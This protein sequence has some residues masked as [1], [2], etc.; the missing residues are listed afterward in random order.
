M[1]II[2]KAFPLR[3][4]MEE[5]KSTDKTTKKPKRSWKKPKDK[6]FRALSAYNLFFQYQRERIVS[7]MDED[8]SPEEISENIEK[9]LKCKRGPKKRKDRISHNRISFVDLAKSIAEKWKLIDPKTKEIFDRYASKEKVRYQNEL[10]SWKMRKES[11]LTSSSNS[12]HSNVE[13]DTTISSTLSKRTSHSSVNK[14]SLQQLGQNNHEI[15]GDVS[16]ATDTQKLS[17]IRQYNMIQRQQS[18][19]K[20][21]MGF[22]QRY[23]FISNFGKSCD[24]NHEDWPSLFPHSSRSLGEQIVGF[25]ST[26]INSK[27]TRELSKGIH[28]SFSHEYEV[29]SNKMSQLSKQKHLDEI[30][31]K[32]SQLKQEQRQLQRQI[33]SRPIIKVSA[34]DSTLNLKSSSMHQFPLKDS[35]VG[36]SNDFSKS[37][38]YEGSNDD[39]NQSFCIDSLRSNLDSG[40][41]Q[42]GGDFHQN[43]A[44]FIDNTGFVSL[45]TAL[46]Y[47]ADDNARNRIKSNRLKSTFGIGDNNIGRGNASALNITECDGH[48]SCP[49]SFNTNIGERPAYGRKLTD[50]RSVDGDISPLIFDN[51]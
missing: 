47:S 37:I 41:E 15:V 12:N 51:F 22:K 40:I 34:W 20:E 10:V 19:L 16:S 38:G 7:G 46:S 23:N 3:M 43:S 30:T 50:E 35:Q 39:D 5:S 32:L 26:A 36:Y 31:K 9:I 2:E 17:Q 44:T 45:P 33:S 4:I 18:I 13:L 42:S 48:S 24:V 11:E 27:Q 6:P 25:T 21:Q 8:G 29:A 1:F 28:S 49:I 14:I